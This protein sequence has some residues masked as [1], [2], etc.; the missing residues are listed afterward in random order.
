MTYLPTIDEASCIGQADCTELLPNVF[1]VVDDVARVVGSGPDEQILQAARDC[2][3]EAISVT[4]SES[5]EQ[6]YP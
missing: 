2:P 4:D 3:V 5:G 1:E 6:V